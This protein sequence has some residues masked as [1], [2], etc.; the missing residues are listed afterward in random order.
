MC[1]GCI[2]PNCVEKLVVCTQKMNATK[3][4]SQLQEHLAHSIFA[5]YGVENR[6]F[7][8]HQDNAP[9]QRAKIT[10]SYLDHE[11]INILPWPPQR[12]DLNIIEKVWQ[13][14]KNKLNFNPRG[15]PRI[16]DELIERIQEVWQRIPIMYLKKLYESIPRRLAAVQNMRG[17]ST[18]YYITTKSY[19]LS[20]SL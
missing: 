5:I 14:M 9:P 15:P 16:K 4:V 19:L 18:K 13:F 12:P 8:F 11:G 20:I 2:G 6:P 1:W 17:Y 7:I 10:K 3:Y